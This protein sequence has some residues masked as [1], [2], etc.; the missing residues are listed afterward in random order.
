MTNTGRI[1]VRLP[2]HLIDELCRE[3]QAVGYGMSWVV[4]RRLEARRKTG[5]P[6]SRQPEGYEP[7]SGGGKFQPQAEA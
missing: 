4:R 2:S 5:S 1:T 6:R 3:G 7:R